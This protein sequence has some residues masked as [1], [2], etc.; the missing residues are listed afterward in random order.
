MPSVAKSLD[1]KLA[2]AVQQF[3]QRLVGRFPVQRMI[4]FGSRARGT[5]R[6]DS[7]A[8]VAVLLDGSPGDFME[9]KLEMVDLACDVHLETGIYTQPFPIWESQWKHPET[10]PHPRLLENIDREG[11]PL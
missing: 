11:I 7:D 9:T 2:D 10:H 8:D 6:S 1:P 4:L 3:A 5:Y